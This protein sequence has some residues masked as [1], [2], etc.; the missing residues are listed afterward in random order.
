MKP[1]PTKRMQRAKLF[2]QVSPPRS[3]NLNKN[4]KNDAPT[5]EALLRS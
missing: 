5:S 4:N 1:C 2:P 3:D